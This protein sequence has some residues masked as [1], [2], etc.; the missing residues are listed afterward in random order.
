[1]RFYCEI[2]L[3]PNPEVNLNFLWSKAFQ[4]IHLGLVEMQDDRK[5]VPI[6]VGFPEYMIGEK[7]ARWVVS[8]GCLLKTK[9]RWLGLTP[10]SGW[11]G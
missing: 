7:I 2:T 4:Q 11:I 1:M 6:G 3:L 8:V 5:Q 10:Q 9:P